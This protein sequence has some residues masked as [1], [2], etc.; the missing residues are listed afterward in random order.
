MAALTC[1]NPP[2]GYFWPNVRRTCSLTLL[3]WDSG[4]DGAE[5]ELDIERG[6]GWR[7]KTETARPRLTSC[8]A[9][10]G[11]WAVPTRPGLQCP[12]FEVA[13]RTKRVPQEVLDGWVET[14]HGPSI[15]TGPG[16]GSPC[17]PRGAGRGLAPRVPGKSDPQEVGSSGDPDLSV[18][19]GRFSALGPWASRAQGPRAADREADPTVNLTTARTGGASQRLTP[20]LP[21][22]G[23]R[24]VPRGRDA[25]GHTQSSGPAGSQ[26]HTCQA[27]EAPAWAFTAD[28]AQI[29]ARPQSLTEV[30][31]PSPPPAD[32]MVSALPGGTASP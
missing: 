6:R 31:R 7:I 20:G 25:T 30:P 13:N 16:A 2:V 27:A 3:S 18:A 26:S 14:A 21:I 1:F 4:S 11:A 28:Q 24:E 8:L 22:C 5:G 32:G 23:G 29:T 9:G 12:P 17:R 15:E 10:S 19:T